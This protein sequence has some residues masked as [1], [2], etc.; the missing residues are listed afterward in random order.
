M[1]HQVG[2]PERCGMLCVSGLDR[3]RIA[4]CS[5]MICVPSAVGVMDHARVEG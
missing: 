5:S 1:L 4:W 3:N 2:V